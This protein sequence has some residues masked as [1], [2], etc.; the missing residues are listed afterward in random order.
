MN[1]DEYARCLAG[2]CG[3]LNFTLDP[4]AQ[5]GRLTVGERQQLEIIRLLALG[6][7]ILILDE[8]TTG[9]SEEQKDV[10]FNA[11]KTL[12]AEGNSI[13]LVSHKLEDTLALCD[14]VTV[15]RQGVAVGSR[16][17]P[18]DAQSLLDM[19][20]NELSHQPER[21]V[22][23][24]GAT[25]LELEDISGHGGRS[26]LNRCNLIV[27]RKEVIGL[28][29]LEGSGQSVF[30]R[31]AAGLQKAEQGVVKV[32]GQPISSG[33]YHAFRKAGIAFLPSS[34]LEEGL[35]PGLTI[36]EHFSLRNSSGFF[37]DREA[38]AARARRKIAKFKISGTPHSI[39]ESLSGG[40]QQRLLLSFLPPSPRLL[41]LENPTR[42]LDVDSAMWVWR[43]L[44]E[45]YGEQSALVFSSSE[46][47]EIMMVADRILIFYQ[48][49]IIK[50]V[51]RNRTDAQE[52]G[53][54]IAGKV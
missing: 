39:V 2:Y 38:S 47:D 19:M 21:S 18:L 24:P 12:A 45:T 8:P 6:T 48:G 20:F 3:H 17:A 25:I 51:P 5:V 40:N 31:I 7:R 16:R 42:G 46:L 23:S 54:A 28:A 29:G 1:A 35:I 30:L 9:I 52:L 43:H 41:L 36:A 44:L 11:L 34:R 13:L 22:P 27:R 14:T 37:V 50:D 4:Y 15:L 32:I 26:G 10:L 53:R 49:S 33:R